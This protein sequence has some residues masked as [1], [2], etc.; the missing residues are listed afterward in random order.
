MD[1]LGHSMGGNIAMSYAGCAQRVRRLINLEGFGLP[2]NPPDAAPQRLAQW[3]D[4]LKE[5]AQLSPMPAW[6]R[7]LPGCKEQPAPAR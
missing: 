5:P 1:L 7:W 4:E 3:L 6:P 2:D